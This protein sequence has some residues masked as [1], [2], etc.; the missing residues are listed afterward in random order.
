[1]EYV[2]SVP[3]TCQN[4]VVQG[5]LRDSQRTMRLSRRLEAPVARL[6]SSALPW[7]GYVPGKSGRPEAF[8]DDGPGGVMDLSRGLLEEEGAP[9]SRPEGYI[10]SA[11]SATG[12][13][14]AEGSGAA[15]PFS[16]SRL[17]P[18]PG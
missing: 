3:V 11:D 7:P 4:E 8:A 2:F 15:K 6:A 10:E 14:S 5:T 17:R 13:D 12:V 9:I 16:N 18:P 1:M